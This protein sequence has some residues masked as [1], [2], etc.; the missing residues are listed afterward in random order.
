[1]RSK[2]YDIRLRCRYGITEDEYWA[3]WESQD[4]L[5]AICREECKTGQRLSVDHDHGTE[6][7]RGLLC[8]ACNFRLGMIEKPGLEDFL[9]YLEART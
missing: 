6:R 2:A 8:R 5:C 9:A 4:G 1:M 7:V 3:I